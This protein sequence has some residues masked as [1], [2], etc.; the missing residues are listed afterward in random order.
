MNIVKDRYEISLWEDVLIEQKG[1]V[2]EHYE[3][4]KIAVIGSDTMTAPFRALQPRLTEN[5]NGTNTLTFKMYYTYINTETGLKE[6]NPFLKLLINERKVKVLWKN[7]W[8]DFVVKS[9][10]ENSEDKSIT[11]TCK[12]LYINELSKNGFNLEF[13]DELQ[14]N[15]GTV[16]EL[17]EKV[18][19]GTD[20]R[21]GDSDIIKQT[22]EE[23]LYK[24]EVLNTFTAK[25]PDN[26]NVTV[27][28]G[29]FIYVFYSVV[30]TQSTNGQFI[31]NANG[32]Y[33]TDKNS[34][35]LLETDCL[36]VD[37]TWSTDGLTARVGGNAIFT[38]Q[39]GQ[40]VSNSFKGKR[41]VRSQKQELDPLTKIYCNVFKDNS[42]KTIYGYSKTVYRDVT[43][44]F[45][46]LS[47]SEDF[48]STHGWIG[49]TVW[50]LAPSLET[51]ES[52]ENYQGKSFLRATGNLYNSGLQN[53]S[54]Y[55][56]NGFQKG[57][58]Y[59][60]RLK[61]Q[62]DSGDK[63]SGTMLRAN[64]A[65]TIKIC[66]WETDPATGWRK[67]KSGGSTYFKTV[68]SP[69]NKDGWIEYELVCTKS[70]SRS[71]IVTGNMGLF[72]IFG[73]AVRW[74]ESA[75]FFAETFGEDINGNYTRINPGEMDKQSIAVEYF[76]YFEKDQM[77]INENDIEYL[78]V[79]TVPWEG[80]GAP[81]PVYNDNYE[82]IRSINAKNSNRF[83]LLQTLAETF[84]CWVR[85]N[86]EHDQ[87]TGKIIYDD[88]GLPKKFV[89]FV[90]EV[91]QE[92]GVGFSYGIDLKTI[93]RNVNSDQITTKAI[94]MPN[95]NSLAENGVCEIAQS[96]ENYPKENFILNFD[97]YLSHGLLSADQLNK[98]LYLAPD[99][100][101]Y[102]LHHLNTSYYALLEEIAAKKTE[103]LKQESLLTLY[104]QYISSFDE[105]ITALKS[106]LVNLAGV[107]AYS[108]TAL[109]NYIKAN[110]TNQKVI[111]LMT[112]LK[113]KE[114][115]RNSYAEQNLALERG[116]EKLKTVL[117]GDGGKEGEREEI[118]DEI[119]ALHKNF[120]QKYARFIQE[121]TWT[122]P[123]YIDPDKYYFDAQNM[124]YTSSRP[125]ISYNINVL[126]LSALEEYKHKTF[127]IGDISFIEDVEFFGYQVVD[128]LVT[129][130][131]YKEKVLISEI[132]SY[133]DTPE[134]D[135]L[136]IQNY[137]TQFDDL[138]QR[139]V[140]STQSLQYSS[141]EFQRAA[142]I[143]NDDGTI[144]KETLQNSFAVNRDMVYSAQNESILA[145]NT[146]LTLSDKND[147]SKKTKLTSG[148][149]FI[150]V[151]GGLTWK[152]AIRGEGVATQYLTAGSI[153][154]N[155]IT[156]LDGSAP[157]FRWD[158]FG[159]DA[160]RQLYDSEGVK[161]GVS[162]GEFVRFDQY[163]IYGIHR[164]GEITDYDPSQADKDGD[165]GVDR[166]KKEASF[167]LLWDGFFLKNRYGDG[168]VTISSE[169]DFVVSDGTH[170][171][172]KIGNLGDHLFPRYG[173]VIN[174]GSGRPVLETDDLGKLWLKNR[175]DI[176]A[177]GSHKIGIGYLDLVLGETL[178]RTIDVN[179][180][181]I[182]YEDGSVKALSGEFTGT[183]HATDG[184][185][186]GTVYAT[187]G[188]FTGLI[189]ATGG[190]IGDLS[191]DENGIYT[192]TTRLDGDGLTISGGGL[193]VTDRYGTAALHF[194]STTG[195]L[196]IEGE[197]NATGGTF[198]GVLEA[199]T[200]SFTGSVT[201]ESGSIGGFTIEDGYLISEDAL[202]SIKLDGENGIITAKT[203]NLG[204]GASVQEYL[205]LGDAYIRNPKYGSNNGLFIEAG[206]VKLYEDGTLKLG[207]IVADG[208]NSILYGD[209]WNITPDVASFQNI[210]AQGGTIENVVFRTSST[211]AAGG[212][213]IFK[214]SAA[215]VDS[216]NGLTFEM[217]NGAEFF[218]VGDFVVLTGEGVYVETVI[219]N[220]VG[221]NVTLADPAPGAN[222]MV[223]LSGLNEE[224]QLVDS[225]LIGI[226]PNPISSGMNNH[227]NQNL[228]QSG[229]TFTAPTGHANGKLNYPSLP[230]LFLG[231]LRAIGKDGF[232]L[233]GDNVYLQGTLT[234][235][236]V[237][238]GYAGINTLTGVLSN[239]FGAEDD[240]IFM[241]AGAASDEEADI[242]NAFFQVTESG[243]IFA[244]KGR[245][246]GSLITNSIIQGSD[247]YT[248][249]LHG[250]TEE[251]AAALTIYDSKLGIV[252]KTGFE[253]E[254]E[255][256]EEKLRITNNG[257]SSD[258]GNTYFIELADGIHF[259]GDTMSLD[260]LEVSSLLLEGN[261]I[262]SLDEDDHSKLSIK[263]GF[264]FSVGV[265]EIFNIN[266]EGI[267][268][269]LNAHFT[270]DILFGDGVNGMKFQ[271][272]LDGYDLYVY[273]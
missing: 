65:P 211:Q 102:R 139:I 138:F 114:S 257:F 31:Y 157:S 161:R 213:M 209:N 158:R 28:A 166:I 106:D 142:N 186:T 22:T 184:E 147:P 19:E 263:D 252:F 261:D 149:L 56:E 116:I 241:W 13:S 112:N 222:V 237:D 247:I 18:L 27:P 183:V 140:A 239:K 105:E 67:P 272:T 30:Q 193:L 229:L 182:V 234:T 235:K 171:R 266:T 33:H 259:Y 217:E 248:A 110:P 60:F 167:G 243:N 66:D 137:K 244:N 180:K 164:P 194:D 38:I 227:R 238:G 146:G 174:D 187:D 230:I 265:N 210:L 231:D 85:F 104:S 71:K 118:L 58:R 256:G 199:A 141:G 249:R 122:S 100:Y 49:S 40:G 254:I 198:S 270:R 15:Q 8:Y 156:I 79:D 123:D 42:N 103:L 41:L 48:S 208:A 169:E 191:I 57:M 195:K 50:K 170:N 260:K 24:V 236:S 90:A 145:D 216:G 219:T 45:N 185:F 242:Q 32:E 23:A 25:D 4:E 99:G 81:T 26:V 176:R 177:N 197:I 3:E 189:H 109:K 130:T 17:A 250:G 9:V 39:E 36:S 73:S 52:L 77:A 212:L 51:I 93:S 173:I 6:D 21:V 233:Y 240:R 124:A 75:Q 148:G 251:S 11:Y 117:Y 255:T 84:E 82:K 136:Q 253:N 221:S 64:A 69:V 214:P 35:L 127:G 34:Q 115:T 63:P 7:K 143:I 178:H 129:T 262:S 89:S 61:A 74:I 188:E 150:S 225:L 134:E 72:I 226:N 133:F 108:D 126:R 119:K 151:D 94:I 125:K 273:N 264:A 86:I 163:G 207:S 204:T 78:Y 47:N 258:G 201:A 205:K 175:L 246:E 232:G 220:I 92:T 200:G 46:L 68:G 159:L 202:E 97:Y 269:E 131:P 29:A 96:K 172:I 62:T 154:T 12:D 218:E 181:F 162:V 165:S 55:I 224:N 203:I 59:I 223:K 155:H 83:N 1:T 135:T 113:G 144:N 267:K 16:V 2:P 70:I 190:T 268:T 168:Y 5:I 91:G 152:N 80:P 192:S 53:S 37:I 132:T 101:F 20:W 153:N 43:T 111:N 10:Q 245:F 196:I 87:E 120:Y 215:L 228:F 95:I 179:N 54:S 44:V 128:G 107:N 121:G 88:Q 160:Y 206:G 271:K 98:D 14:N 76:H